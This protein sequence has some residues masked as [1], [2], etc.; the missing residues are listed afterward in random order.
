MHQKKEKERK[1]LRGAAFSF[2]F[3]FHNQP[4]STQS[5]GYIPNRRG[6]VVQRHA[7]KSH[8]T[9]VILRKQLGSPFRCRRPPRARNFPPRHRVSSSAQ[10]MPQCSRAAHLS[11]D[12][13]E[14]AATAEAA[15]GLTCPRGTVVRGEVT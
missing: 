14:F 7:K 9:R 10:N 4:A 8:F 6:S 11:G 5:R 15:R 1:N 12:K 3:L 2:S 13:R